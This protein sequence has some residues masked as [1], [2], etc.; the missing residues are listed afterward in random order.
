MWTQLEL[1][2][3]KTEEEFALSLNR[4]QLGKLRDTMKR[5]FA[6]IMSIRHAYANYNAMLRKI[7]AVL[8]EDLKTAKYYRKPE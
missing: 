5:E 3:E 8:Q 7:E 1:F 4:E 2:D 6:W